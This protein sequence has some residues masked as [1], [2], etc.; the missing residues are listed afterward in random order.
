MKNICSLITIYKPNVPKLKQNI[1]IMLSLNV[2]N[3]IIPIY[4]W[5]KNNKSVR[6]TKVTSVNSIITSGM[7]VNIQ[8]FLDINGFNEDF[9]VDFCD[10]LF[11]W[12]ALYNGYSILQSKDAYLIHESGDY[13]QN[14]FSYT[15]YSRAPYRNYFLI[16]DSLNICFRIKETPLHIRFRYFFLMPVRMFIY[17]LLFDNKNIRLKMYWL[18]FKDFFYKKKRFG[19]ISKILDANIEDETKG[20]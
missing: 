11:C 7:L 18:G 20:I 16:R 2:R 13:N 5:K 17:L 15:M 9:P 1:E 3:H 12:K 14:I 10:Y 19:S 8:A 6:S 4:N